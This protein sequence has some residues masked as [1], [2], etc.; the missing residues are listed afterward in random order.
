MSGEGGF[1]LGYSGLVITI[2]GHEELFF[3]FGYQNARDDCWVHLL[4]AVEAAK[5]QGSTV[6]LASEV[7]EAEVAKR[8][9]QVLQ[10]AR[11][12]GHAGHDLQLPTT[13]IDSK[14][15]SS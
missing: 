7:V 12:A 4:R 1:K 11:Y 3:E 15:L 5:M 6:L 10:D 14:S 8:E 13:T 9:Y 2:R